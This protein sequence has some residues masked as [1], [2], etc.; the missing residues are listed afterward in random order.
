MGRCGSKRLRQLLPSQG[1]GHRAWEEGKP[2]ACVH[3]P[4]QVTGRAR[5]A[6][7]P[8]SLHSL[9]S[10]G[11]SL[12]A[13]A[14]RAPRGPTFPPEPTSAS[15]QVLPSSSSIEELKELGIFF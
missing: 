15:E 13:E 7:R 11:Q 4:T 1:T 8:G 5:L 14:R 2:A 3:S 12:P 9:G 10:K 6:A